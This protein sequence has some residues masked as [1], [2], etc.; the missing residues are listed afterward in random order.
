MQ[1]RKN[2]PQPQRSSNSTR[3]VDAQTMRGTKSMNKDKLKSDR[4]RTL[5]VK[6]ANQDQFGSGHNNDKRTKSAKQLRGGPRAERDLA[7]RESQQDIRTDKGRRH[8]K[9]FGGTGSKRT[10]KGHG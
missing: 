4:D 2:A 7:Y 10:R 5:S 8:L 1:G 3:G 9:E 6:G